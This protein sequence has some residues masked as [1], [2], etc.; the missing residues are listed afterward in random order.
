MSY[1]KKVDQ[2]AAEIKELQRVVDVMLKGRSD[3]KRQEV[4]VTDAVAALTDKDWDG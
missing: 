1:Q 2:Q 4:F 3:L